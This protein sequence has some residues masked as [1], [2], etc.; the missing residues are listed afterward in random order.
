M[1]F[2]LSSIA[3]KRIDL[4]APSHLLSVGQHPD[5]P[6]KRRAKTYTPRCSAGFADKREAERS[7]LQRGHSILES[8]GSSSLWRSNLACTCVLNTRCVIILSTL[9][10]GLI[11]TPSAI[12]QLENRQMDDALRSFDG[13]L[14][15]KPTNAVALLGKA[16][17]LYTRR[18]YAQALR[19]FQEVL[20]LSPS[21]KPDPRIGIGLCFWA[22]D[23][24][25]QA[26]AAW[27]RSLEVVSPRG[28]SIFSAV[29]LS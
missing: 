9:N 21:C 1:M 10:V 28:A 26:K 19:L 15:I 16:R 6:S 22:L 17:I 24:K 14:A 23:H 7:L 20:R 11:S 18:Q 5:C 2:A 13:V 27:E 3:S 12:Y 4:V 29:L 8:G 25:A